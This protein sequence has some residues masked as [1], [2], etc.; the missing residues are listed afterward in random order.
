VAK[1]IDR[2]RLHELLRGEEERVVAE[3]D[4]AARALYESAAFPTARESPTAQ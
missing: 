2:D 4:T 3:H 1:E